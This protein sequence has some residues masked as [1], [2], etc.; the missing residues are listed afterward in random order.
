MLGE[1]GTGS[2]PPSKGDPTQP[3]PSVRGQVHATYR[4]GNSSGGRTERTDIRDRRGSRS[5]VRK[6]G[7]QIDVNKKE[8]STA[9]RTRTLI[10][11][12]RQ[13]NTA[14]TPPQWVVLRILDGGLGQRVSPLMNPFARAQPKVLPRMCGFKVACDV[15]GSSE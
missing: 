9:D 8:I 3:H 12:S 6:N 5:E 15:E 4:Y 13:T 2:A 1:A 11:N 14:Q 7:I 10:F